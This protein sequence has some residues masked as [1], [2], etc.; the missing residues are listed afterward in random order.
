MCSDRSS[1]ASSGSVRESRRFL[2]VF[3]VAVMLLVASSFRDALWAKP[4]LPVRRP[5][6]VGMNGDSLAAIDVAVQ[7]SLDAGNMPGCVV[8]VGRRGAIVHF[9]AYGYR[10]LVP[11]KIKMTPDTVF[12][13]AS[14]TKPI[15]T[16]TSVMLLNERKAIQLDDPVAKHI[17]EFAANGKENVTIRQLLTHQ[18]GLLADNS[19]RDYVDSTTAL[20]RIYALRL[21]YPPETKFVYS[22]V[23]F[24]VLGELVRRVSKENL[25]AMT[26]KNIFLPLGMEETG[27]VPRAALRSRAAPTQQRE[28]KWLQGEVHDP[29][30]HRLGGIAG[31]AG[32]FST[33]RDLSKYAQML[34]L[35]GRYDSVQ[36]LLPETVVAMTTP[37][38]VPG[39]IRG[40][41]WDM[42]TGYSSNRGRSFS[43][44]AFGHGGFTGTSIWMDPELQLFVIFLSN[45]V[46]PDGQGSVNKLAGQIGSIA[47]DSIDKP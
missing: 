2:P 30:A 43:D 6:A 27:Y 10:Q 15:A 42:R 25:H 33:A 1:N 23:G 4:D 32:L 37:H 29:R 17:P 44:S 3:R 7:Q 5:N 34:L 36:I 41:G 45:R 14:L 46:H 24:I 47:A 8:V 26:Q 11:T 22:D 19:L 12:D 16:A 40:L 35:R 39:G 20:D 28:G 9:K 21:S 13:L 38:P 31:H 18:S